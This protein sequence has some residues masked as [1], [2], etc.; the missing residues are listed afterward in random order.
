M[1]VVKLTM[2]S[3]NSKTGPIPVSTTYAA[4]C[5][6]V[7]PLKKGGC[8]AEIG[9]LALHWRKV[10]TVG[11]TWEDFCDKIKGLRNGTFWRHNAAGD[12][13][14]D[15]QVIDKKTLSMLVRANKGK[16]GFTY[17]H[18]D[19]QIASNRMVVAK[20]NA[21]GFTVNLSANNLQH[22]DELLAYGIAPVASVVALDHPKLSYTPK[23]NKV[24][25]CPA[26]Y[27]NDVTCDSCRLCQR[28]DRRCVVAF[29]VHGVAK[30]KAQTST[31]NFVSRSK[32]IAT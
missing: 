15:K 26:T 20:A 30:K 7:C 1:K 32:A 4:S 6:D 11:D 19:M 5:P 23:G 3:G 13:L 2:V 12:L 25:V 22:A 8:Y 17:T 27:R 9:P 18:H 24:V 10:E 16:M 31:I 21:Y 14:H 29:P 28:A